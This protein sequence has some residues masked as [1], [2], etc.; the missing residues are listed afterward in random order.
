MDK[1]ILK[2]ENINLKIENFA[3]SDINLDLFRG[4]I[5][6]VMGENRSGKSL[7]MQIISGVLSPDSGRLFWNGK[8]LKYGEYSS[9]IKNDI[10]YVR[11]DSE[12]L[13]NL[14]VSEN[15]F[16]NNL[17][18][19]N[20]ILKSI[21]YDRLNYMCQELLNELNLPISINDKVSSLGL[22][23]RQICEFLRAY[24]SKAKIVILDE[25]F[26]ALTQSE[27]DL[28]CRIVKGIR[29]RGAGI[30]YITHSL[31]D[32]FLLGD[33]ITIIKDGRIIDTRKVSDC[34]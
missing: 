5:H 14:T 31:E 15:L 17:P 29:E 3:L 33:R 2:L 22:A 23:Q 12:M 25:P 18:Y 30:F 4:E 8:E 1:P 16:F 11:Q 34:T 10:T 6:V 24:V 32:V 9:H 7:L 20:K 13:T 28:L 19:K 27:R 21:D 26:A